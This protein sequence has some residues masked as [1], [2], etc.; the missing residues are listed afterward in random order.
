[1]KNKLL[2]LNALLCL[3]LVV[4]LAKAL[5]TNRP[6]QEP[7]NALTH[8]KKGIKQERASNFQE[9]LKSYQRAVE[10]EPNF[11][12]AQ[13]RLAWVYGALEQYKAAVRAFER[14]IELDRYVAESYA[15]LGMSYLGL[16]DYGNAAE[17]FEQALRLKPSLKIRKELSFVYI[18]IGKDKEAAEIV[19]QSW[20]EQPLNAQQLY[21]QGRDFLREGQF[22]DAVKSFQR[23]IE[24]DTIF[25][26]AYRELGFLAIS[27]ERPAFMKSL[28]GLVS[29]IRLCISTLDW[30][31]G[32]SNN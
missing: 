21:V 6:L 14:A 32:N 2:L 12:Y 10:L 19:E 30:L 15:N 29:M 4:H 23:A 18:Q 16:K 17:A 13:F 20:R 1:M 3:M 24:L 7:D 28:L 31:T 8:F 5:P 27:K 26:A 11:L 22:E 25:T 9:A